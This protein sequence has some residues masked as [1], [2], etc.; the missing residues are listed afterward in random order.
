MEKRHK[1]PLQGISAYVGYK[2]DK[3]FLLQVAIKKVLAKYEITSC[4]DFRN[5]VPEFVLEYVR[6][7]RLSVG[8]L[9]GGEVILLPK[10]IHESSLSKFS[11][12]TAVRTVPAEE[13]KL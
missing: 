2:V 6:R 13:Y 7:S 1:I 4:K 10:N 11:R 9:W 12:P 5:S 3:S 8:K